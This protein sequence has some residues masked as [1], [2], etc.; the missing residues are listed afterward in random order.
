MQPWGDLGEK[1]LSAPRGYT[2]RRA[3]V[4]CM[5]EISQAAGAH[6]PHPI[7]KA[8]WSRFTGKYEVSS[9]LHPDTVVVDT[10]PFRALA[11][12]EKLLRLLDRRHG[13][14]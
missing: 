4:G 8:I 3:K 10:D 5:V 14:R 2:P 7:S 13:S 6:P 11:D 12:L 9:S 1:S